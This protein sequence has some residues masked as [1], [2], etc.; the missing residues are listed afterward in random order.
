MCGVLITFCCDI[1]LFGYATGA[2]DEKAQ[3]VSGR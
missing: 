2:D 1:S 3:I